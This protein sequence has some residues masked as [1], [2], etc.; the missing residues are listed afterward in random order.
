MHLQVDLKRNPLNNAK[1]KIILKWI[2]QINDVTKLR[3][4]FAVNTPSIS[5]AKVSRD[6]FFTD[7]F[8]FSSIPAS[9]KSFVNC[10]SV[11]ARNFASFHSS[12]HFNWKLFLLKALFGFFSVSCFQH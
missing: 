7:P 4:V 11:L 12:F 6:S 9:R 2:T 3:D 1:P 10:V 5:S 8:I